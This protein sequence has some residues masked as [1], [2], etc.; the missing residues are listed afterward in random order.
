MMPRRMSSYKYTSDNLFDT[1]RVSTIYTVTIL[2]F[3]I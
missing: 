1:L 3:L 2:Q